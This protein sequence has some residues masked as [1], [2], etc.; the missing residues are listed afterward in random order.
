[1]Q[2]KPTAVL[3]LEGGYREDRHG[4]RMELPDSVPHKPDWLTGIAAE[5][6]YQT[7]AMLS[8]CDGLLVDIDAGLLATYCE[9]WQTYLD[10]QA[11]VTREGLIATSGNGVQYQHPAVGIRNKARYE[12]MRIGSKFGM[13]P[14]DRAKLSIGGVSEDE[15]ARKYLT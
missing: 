4:G 14:A 3:Q 10:A 13:S 5:V 15:L 11:I 2:A 12:I 1:M 8:H 7:V 6:W 9:A